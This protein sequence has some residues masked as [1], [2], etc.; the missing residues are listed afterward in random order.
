MSP[1]IYC[2][3][4]KL[5]DQALTI[6]MEVDINGVMQVMVNDVELIPLLLKAGCGANKK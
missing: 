2:V 4:C 6:F 3:L 5:R 1:I